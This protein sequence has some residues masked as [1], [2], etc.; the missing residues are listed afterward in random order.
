[1]SNDKDW[2]VTENGAI[3]FAAAM[4]NLM[5]QVVELCGGEVVNT[6]EEQDEDKERDEDN[7][8]DELLTAAKTAKTVT[9]RDIQLAIKCDEELQKLVPNITISRATLMGGR[10]NSAVNEDTTRRTENGTQG[11]NLV[12]L[13]LNEY[14]DIQDARISSLEQQLKDSKM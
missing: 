11:G 3:P 5:V 4:E 9:L 7:D 8:Q 10:S 14:K 1:M 13:T 6:V 2:E 12:T